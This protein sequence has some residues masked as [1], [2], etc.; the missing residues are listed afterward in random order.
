MAAPSD[1][2]LSKKYIL[3][4]LDCAGCAAQIEAEVRRETGLEDVGINFATRSIFIPPQFAPAVQSIVDRIEPG[5]KLVEAAALEAVQAGDGHH[6][7][8]RGARGEAGREAAGEE[9]DEVFDKR[10]LAEIAVAAL[11]FVAGIAFHE[12]LHETPFSLGEYAVLL[13]AYWL[14]GKG[15]V[16]AAIRNLRRGQLFDET[17][18]MTLATAGAILIHEIPEAVGVMLFYSVG[19]A[20]Q[21]Y[22]VG[23]SR[24]SIKALVDIRPDYANVRRGG[25]TVRV[26]P[27]EVQVGEEIVVRPGERIPL[28]GEVIAGSSFVDTSALTGEPVPRK[29]EPGDAVLAGTVNSQGLLTVR[30]SKPFAESAVSKILELVESAGARKAPTERFITRFARYYTPAVV[31]AALGVALLPPLFVEG[32]QLSEWVYRALVLLVI[33]CPCALFLSIP[34][35]YFGGIGGASRHGILVKGASVL[36]ALT[37]L[38]TVVMDKTGTLT[39]GVF[40]VQRV[41]ALNGFSEAA[42]LDYAAHA[43]SFSNHPIAGSILE[44]FVEARGKALDRSRVGR[45]EEIGGHGVKAEVDGKLVVAGNDR[46]LHRENVPH[47]D[48]DA[49]GTVVNVAVDGVLAGR[50]VVADELKPDAAEAVRSLKELGIRRTAMLTGDDPNVAEGVAAAVGIDEVHAGLLPEEKVQALEAIARAVAKERGSGAGRVAFV[51]DGINDAPVLMRADVGIAMGALGSDAAIEAADVVIMDDMPSK[52]GKAIAIAR[53]TRAIV[54]QNIAFALG[55]KAAV[56]A[57]GA[58]GHASMWEAVFADV[59]VSLLAVLNATRVLR[60]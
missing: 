60:A 47:D 48:C 15:V 7:S 56:I 59:G 29:V 23:R 6:L 13:P 31:A 45:Y 35:G 20:L 16:T 27:G 41:T 52:V 39:Q 57:L 8:A 19:E 22:A 51:G 2:A 46:L 18:L 40:K 49:E 53:R 1:K 28:D 12:P 36:D 37:Q 43:E 26:A 55:V 11:L 14:V 44:A 17:F 54:L 3:E 24:A 4:G 34:L 21:D 33:S 50:I 42:V 25:E 9:A 58:A 5:V 32:A 10:P 30:V 38:D